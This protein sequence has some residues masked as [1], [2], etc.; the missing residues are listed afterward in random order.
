MG[1]W[2]ERRSW[3]P[4]R[5]FNFRLV[6]SAPKSLRRTNSG[7]DATQFS[8]GTDGGP[9]GN[10]GDGGDAGSG[11]NG[12]SGGTIRLSVTRDDTHLL[13]IC[14]DYN[15]SGGTGGQQGI[16]GYGGECMQR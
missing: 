4:V 3:S 5:F 16:P 7:Q 1:E 13:M 9:G 12:A 15:V 8:Y 6:A 11:G 2:S 10:G 14:S